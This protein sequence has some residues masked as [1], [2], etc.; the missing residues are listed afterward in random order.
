MNPLS[1]GRL[2]HQL[3]DAKP[4]YTDAEAVAEA[5]RCLYCHDAPCVQACP[6]GIDIPTFIRKISTGNLRGSARVILS[7]NMLGYSCARACPVEVL[8]A[9][10]CVYN[11]WHRTPIAIGRLQRHAVEAEFRTGDAT[12]L[13]SR[14]PANGHKV[15][16]VGAGPAAQPANAVRM[17]RST[18][19]SLK[20]PLTYRCA[21][22]APTFFA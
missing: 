22:R 14:A 10:A 13:F 1:E 20:T 17:A 5:N 4:L 7:A 9:G 19:A 8:C 15:A 3:P 2:E 11:T 12:R 6:T 18:C 21:R 16:C